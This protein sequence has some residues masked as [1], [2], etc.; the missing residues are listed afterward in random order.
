MSSRFFSYILNIGLMLFVFATIIHCTINNSRSYFDQLASTD[1]VSSNVE[2]MYIALNE[3]Y[4]SQNGIQPILYE[5]SIDDE[6]VDPN[7]CSIGKDD[8]SAEDKLFAFLM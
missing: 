1:A 7:D 3:D 6:I 4:Y 8:E 2:R 5:L